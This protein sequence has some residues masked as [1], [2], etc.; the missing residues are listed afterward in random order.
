MSGAQELQFPS[1]GAQ[2]LQA[3]RVIAGR[4]TLGTSG[5]T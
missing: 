5:E 1:S 3:Q 2:G 4:W